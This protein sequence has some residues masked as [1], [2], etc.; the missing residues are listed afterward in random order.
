MEQ[1]GKNMGMFE[2][3]AFPMPERIAMC[4]ANGGHSIKYWEFDIWPIVIVF[5]SF[6]TD[7]LTFIHV[8]YKHLVG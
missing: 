1:A 3:L 7:C 6:L 8:S 5:F 4:I 2:N